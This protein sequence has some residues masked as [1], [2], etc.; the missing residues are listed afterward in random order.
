MAK[1]QH[2]SEVFEQLRKVIDL[3]EHC[4]EVTIHLSIDKAPTVTAVYF[5]DKNN[6]AN[7]PVTQRF[8]LEPLLD[9]EVVSSR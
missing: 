7:G 4:R 3:P 2:I 1:D 8:K 6:L 9:S 5:P